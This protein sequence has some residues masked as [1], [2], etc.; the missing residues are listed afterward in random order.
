M[1]KINIIDITWF[2]FSI[3]VTIFIYLWIKTLSPIIWFIESDLL[4]PENVT[5]LEINSKP[6]QFLVWT[7]KN[8]VYMSLFWLWIIFIIFLLIEL[9]KKQINK[10]SWKWCLIY[11]WI[12]LLI[13]IPIF[14][15][16][17]SRIWFI[18]AHT[19]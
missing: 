11:F 2:I 19:Y 6:I 12:F 13:S 8:E 5:S 3:C 4:W 16:L 15:I 18:I 17:K 9:Y 7:T 14:M 1:K 10:F